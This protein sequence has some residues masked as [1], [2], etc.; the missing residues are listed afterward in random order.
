MPHDFIFNRDWY[1]NEFG[2]YAAASRLK[3]LPELTKNLKKE[4][5]AND[6]YDAD[7]IKEAIK[8]FT[9]FKQWQE[10]DKK[11]Y[12]AAQR[13]TSNSHHSHHS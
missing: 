7:K 3:I 5:V 9:S 6:Y 11:T 1:E 12:A 8:D 2:A 13:R 10:E 4:I